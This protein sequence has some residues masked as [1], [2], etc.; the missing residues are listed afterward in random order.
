MLL[1]GYPYDPRRSDEVVAI[2]NGAGFRTIVPY[3]RGYGPTRFLSLETPR[4]G[5]QAALG[6]DLLE[7]LDA[8]K[9]RQAVLAGFDWGAR[10]ACIVAALWPERVLGLVTC[11]GYQ[12]QDIAGSGKPV[13]PEQEHPVSG[14]STFSNGTRTQRPGGEASD[15]A[16]CYGSSGRRPGRSTRTYGRTASSFDNPDFVDVVIHSY[17]HRWATPLAIRAM[18]RWKLDWLLCPRSASFL[19]PLTRAG[20]VIV[21]VICQQADIQISARPP[22]V[23]A[24]LLSN[25]VR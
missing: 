11:A 14:T 2:V 10:A 15:L 25:R 16:D 4:S 5:E 12:I 17:R 3:L 9:I 6:Q 1:H 20:V 19:Q 21:C 18:R 13:D 8:L 24:T 7:L 23:T 22:V